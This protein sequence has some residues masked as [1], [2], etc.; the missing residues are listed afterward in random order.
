MQLCRVEEG[1]E[2]LDGDPR[3]DDVGRDLGKHGEGELEEHEE[4]HCG[5][6]DVG[7]ERG[8]RGDRSSGKGTEGDEDGYSTPESHV[9]RLQEVVR[10]QVTR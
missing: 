1:R 10:M 7:R 2:T 4:G 9:Q 5:E 6:D 3:L 8:R